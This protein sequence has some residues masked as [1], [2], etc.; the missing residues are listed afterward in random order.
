MA[1][2]TFPL[3]NKQV[4][5]SLSDI[6]S[7]VE[8]IDSDEPMCDADCG[9]RLEYIKDVLELL[10]CRSEA[11]VAV[12][13]YDCRSAELL[14]SQYI[15]GLKGANLKALS[16]AHVA[17]IGRELFTLCTQLSIRVVADYVLSDHKLV[18]QYYRKDLFDGPT[19]NIGRRITGRPILKMQRL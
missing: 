17:I 13:A 19:N 3:L 7:D 9:D 18:F 5:L 1:N 4:V 16:L 6:I 12:G 11:L 14:L 15:H 2:T 8:I 10:M